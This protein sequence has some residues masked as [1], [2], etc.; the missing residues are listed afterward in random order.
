MYKWPIELPTAP[1]DTILACT[2][3]NKRDTY[4]SY[5]TIK[6]KEDIKGAGKNFTKTRINHSLSES[7]N[8]E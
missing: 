4:T 7:I 8:F 1:T 2:L 6:T 3:R 5:T